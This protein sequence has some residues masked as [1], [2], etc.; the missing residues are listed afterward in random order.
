MQRKSDPA[1]CR[2]SQGGRKG[3]LAVSQGKTLRHV[4]L[5]THRMKTGISFDTT[6]IDSCAINAPLSERRS[7][8]PSCGL[9]A[10]VNP[11]AR[12]G[13]ALLAQYLNI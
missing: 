8:P 6:K 7:S 13:V 12:W 10:G 1:Y 3:S 9:T 11:A 4:V 2:I 5:L